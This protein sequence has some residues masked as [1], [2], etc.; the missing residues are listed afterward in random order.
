MSSTKACAP[1]ELSSIDA[2]RAVFFLQAMLFDFM[3]SGG[4]LLL[5]GPSIDF[6]DAVAN[7]HQST[8]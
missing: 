4:C 8:F 7:G 6:S 5:K 1:N 3:L 2:S